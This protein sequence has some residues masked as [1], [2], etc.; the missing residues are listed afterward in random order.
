[1][2]SPKS[3]PGVQF[4]VVIILKFSITFSSNLCFMNGIQCDDG[5]WP[6]G[7]RASAPLPYMFSATFSPSLGAR[8]ACEGS[9]GAPLHCV[10]GGAR[11]P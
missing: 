11:H 4:S 5:V 1:M 6:G 7:L 10:G 8:G 3:P 2:C 9:A